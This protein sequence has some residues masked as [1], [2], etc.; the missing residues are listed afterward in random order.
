MAVEAAGWTPCCLGCARR[1]TWWYTFDLQESRRG[2]RADSSIGLR[3]Q[4]R[5]RF[6]RPGG[7]WSSVTLLLQSPLRVRCCR[8]RGGGGSVGKYHLH[9]LF[10]GFCIYIISMPETKSQA[11]RSV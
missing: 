2:A 5:T 4:K 3:E 11:T 9:V 10:L 1:P 7:F 6:W 8:C